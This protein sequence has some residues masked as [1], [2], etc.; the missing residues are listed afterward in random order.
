MQGSK[1]EFDLT[2]R[3]LL[4]EIEEE[5]NKHQAR[6]NELNNEIQE[7][8]DEIKSLIHFQEVNGEKYYIKFSWLQIVT[9]F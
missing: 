9:N 2:V 5:E 1:Q 3:K 8:Q 7:Y 6:Q 4:T